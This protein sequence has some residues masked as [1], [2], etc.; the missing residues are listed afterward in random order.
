MTPTEL[1][2]AFFI[3]AVVILLTCR[4]V[5]LVMGRFGQ[6]PVVGEMIAGVVLGPSLFGLVAPGASDAVFPPELKPVLY[7]AGQI[8]LVALMFH[9][10]Y[11]FRAHAGRGLAGTAVTVSAAGVLV[12]L[13]LGVGLTF[14]SDGHVPIFVDGVS[15]WVTAA[16]VGVALAITAFPM[17]ARIIT[18]QGISGTRHGSLSLASGATDDAAAWLMLAGV[19]SVASEKTG[20]IVKALGGSL[21]FVAVLLLVG[22][23]LLAWILTKPGLSDESRLLLTVAV[24]FCGAWFTDTIQLYAVFGAFCIGL[25][26]PRHEASERV[27]RTVQG[28]TQVIFVP[29]F[30]TYS[31]LNTRF[32]VFADPAVMAFGAGCVVLASVG[33]F[34]GCWAAA[35]LCGEP[36]AVAV[37]VG[38]LMN[39][40]G[41][42]QLIALN[43]GLSAGIVG[44]E[45]FAALVLVALVT[46]VM[47][48]PVLNWLDRRDARSRAAGEP[49]G[50][51]AAVPAGS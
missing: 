16:F 51:A 1:A 33:K 36:G 13:L 8:G 14:A 35:K 27:V 21:L 41:L 44:D 29:M 12:P 32:D 48:V 37:R 49:A 47:T 11:E 3:A 15:I 22:R 24:L 9:A 34:G 4:L 6:P 10:G 19:L 42:M 31:G 26:M 28:S 39:A 17:L 40:R 20:P 2:P 18:E 25:S 30:F 38:A 7:V 43:I 45:L 5:V 46:T 23:R 50:T